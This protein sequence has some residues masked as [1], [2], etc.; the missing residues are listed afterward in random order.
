MHSA[1][2]PQQVEGL[3]AI[4]FCCVEVFWEGGGVEWTDEPRR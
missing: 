2:L 3:D 4:V 1:L